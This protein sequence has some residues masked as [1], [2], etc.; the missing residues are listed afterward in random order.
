MAAA[1]LASRP[2]AAMVAAAT[3]SA[4]VLMESLLVERADRPSHRTFDRFS[5]RCSFNVSWLAHSF[6]IHDLLHF[7][8]EQSATACTRSPPHMRMRAAFRPPAPATSVTLA[9]G[10][11]CT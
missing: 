1:G 10:F 4:K 11:R 7:F 5:I 6:Y 2:A 8:H 9:E 3:A